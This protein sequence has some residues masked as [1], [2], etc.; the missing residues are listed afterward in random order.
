MA[1][2]PGRPQ[3]NYTLNVRSYDAGND[4]ILSTP[5]DQLDTPEAGKRYSEILQAKIK[6]NPA[7]NFAFGGLG[8][9]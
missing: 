1:K 5:L 6:A 2:G 3:V 7:A 8:D 4:Y 9:N